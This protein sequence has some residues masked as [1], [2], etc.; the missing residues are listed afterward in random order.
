M[1]EMQAA[2]HTPE[3]TIVDAIYKRLSEPLLST[4]STEDGGFLDALNADGE[5]LKITDNDVIVSGTSIRQVAMMTAIWQVQVERYFALIQTPTG[6]PVDES[7]DEI[8]EEF[9][10]ASIREII[11][12]IDQAIRPNYGDTKKN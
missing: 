7:Y 10:E 3:Q 2:I 5:K 8:A 1:E 11:T 12:K 6:E 9:P 4:V